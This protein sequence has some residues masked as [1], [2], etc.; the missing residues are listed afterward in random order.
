MIGRSYIV[1]YNSVPFTIGEDVYKYDNEHDK[2]SDGWPKKISEV[3]KGKDGGESIPSNLDTV[4]FDMRDKNLYFF[5]N[6]MVS[7][8]FYTPTKFEGVYR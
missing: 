4:F 1:Y 5:K 2:L 3:F 7:C 6:D 8:G